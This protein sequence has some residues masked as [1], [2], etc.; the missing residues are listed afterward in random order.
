M[1]PQRVERVDAIFHGALDIAP[2]E[3]AAF[4]DNACAGGTMTTATGALV[5]LTAYMSP[6]QARGLVVDARSDIWS[7]GVVLFEMISRRLPF[8]GATP[9]DCVAAILERDPEPVS[10]RRPRIPVELERILGRALAKKADER[11]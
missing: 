9:S 5:G 7:L 11:Y 10:R 6:E 3:R 1:N 4:L 2:A 8:T